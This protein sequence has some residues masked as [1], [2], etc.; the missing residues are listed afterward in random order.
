LR[1]RDFR[2]LLFLFIF[3]LLLTAA[4]IRDEAVQLGDE[5]LILTDPKRIRLVEQHRQSFAFAEQGFL[6]T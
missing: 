6:Y 1:I 4:A 3:L 5:E 2:I